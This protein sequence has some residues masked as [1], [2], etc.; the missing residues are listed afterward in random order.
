[1]ATSAKAVTAG[2]AGHHMATSKIKSPQAI[3]A[4]ALRATPGDAGNR[5]NDALIQAISGATEVM[6]P[7]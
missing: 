2:A 1:M 6:T 7:L 3:I 5:R 4:G